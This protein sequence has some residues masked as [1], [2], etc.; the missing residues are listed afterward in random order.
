MQKPILMQKSILMQKL[1]L[2]VEIKMNPKI[3]IDINMKIN[4]YEPIFYFRHTL[5]EIVV[6]TM[7]VQIKV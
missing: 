1:V 5:R 4:T 6:D 7:L 3:D 2:D